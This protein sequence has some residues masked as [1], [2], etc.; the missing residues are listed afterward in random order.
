M[1]QGSRLRSAKKLGES[2]VRTA[3][4]LA[5]RTPWVSD[6]D[7]ETDD[8]RSDPRTEAERAER[9]PWLDFR[10]GNG[11]GNGGSARRSF[12]RFE[13]PPPEEADA[14]EADGPPPERHFTTPMD[15]ERF[16]ALKRLKQGP[17]P[18]LY[19]RHPG[20]ATYALNGSPIGNL[21]H[22]ASY[23]AAAAAAKAAGDD[24]ATEQLLDQAQQ[25][26]SSHPTYYGAAW[27]ALGRVMLTS[28]ALGSCPR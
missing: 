14:D 28:S 22:A 1:A 2:A 26:N 3:A 21:T 25:V 15:S 27:V 6:R 20:M 19:R 4:S 5:E 16:V 23:V 12:P 8:Q 18:P 17:R 7:Q 24:G 11:D 9:T 10:V 13:L